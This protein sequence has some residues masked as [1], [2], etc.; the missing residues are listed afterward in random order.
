MAKTH[1]T[2]G[3]WHRNTYLQGPQLTMVV[4]RGRLLAGL[5][6]V[7]SD[8]SCSYIEPGFRTSDLRAQRRVFSLSRASINDWLLKALRVERT[9]ACG[10]AV[11][12]QFSAQRTRDREHPKQT[13][14]TQCTRQIWP[15][16]CGPEPHMDSA[17][18]ASPPVATAEQNRG[19]S[20]MSVQ[21]TSQ[22]HRHLVAGDAKQ[23]S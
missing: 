1:P 5:T 7:R 16:S 3:G 11:E 20:P 8:P 18:P 13:E 23:Q 4:G 14:P 19:L 2:A 22:V 6:S 10:R 15:V 9:T 21:T 12:L 17:K